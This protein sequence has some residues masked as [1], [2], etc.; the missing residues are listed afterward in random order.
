MC[1]MITAYVWWGV[2]LWLVRGSSFRLVVETIWHRGSDDATPKAAIM[3]RDGRARPR[4]DRC[5]LR[6]STP[7]RLSEIRGYT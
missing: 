3:S 2:G 6:S 4:G 5:R 1:S 7:P